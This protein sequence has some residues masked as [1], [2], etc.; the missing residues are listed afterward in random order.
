LGTPL[1][2]VAVGVQ[3]SLIVWMGLTMP[4][5]WQDPVEKIIRWAAVSADWR[6][7]PTDMSASICRLFSADQL[8]TMAV[9]AGHGTTR[10]VNKGS[11]MFQ[12]RQMILTV[13]PT[14]LQC[15]ATVAVPPPSC[16]L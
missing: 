3:L 11:C 13:D 9:S 14:T 4:W 7:P 5:F 1:R 2:L 8:K 10:W 15:H 12:E 6:D 16:A